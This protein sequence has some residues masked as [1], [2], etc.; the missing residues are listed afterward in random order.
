MKMRRVFLVILFMALSACTNMVKFAHENPSAQQAEQRLELEAYLSQPAG[1]GPFPAVVLLHGCSGLAPR[2]RMWAE[3]LNAWGYATLIV[4]SFGPRWVVNGCHGEVPVTARAHDADAAKAYLRGLPSIDPQ[5]IAVM[6][7][8]NGGEAAM[9]AINE[10]CFP[11]ASGSPFAAAL[12]FYPN[13][14]GDL[15]SNTAPLLVLIGEK[16]DWTPAGLCHDLNQT[17]RGGHEADF[18]FYANAEHCFDVPGCNKIYMGHRVKYD[19]PAAEDAQIR[20]KAFLA[21]YLQ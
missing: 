14:T 18:A 12:A 13:C 15:P 5:R 7:F 3:R 17:P 2:S 19:K 6:G 21:Q 10:T 16:D 4:D 8:A 1:D 11:D 9:C 20:V